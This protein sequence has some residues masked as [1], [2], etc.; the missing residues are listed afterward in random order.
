MSF[1]CSQRIKER[2]I[3]LFNKSLES[4]GFQDQ[5]VLFISIYGSH[6]YGTATETS[7]FDLLVVINS[8][9]DND[10]HVN[11]EISDH[12]SRSI[13]IDDVYDSDFMSVT[14]PQKRVGVDITITTFSSFTAA[15]LKGEP[16]AIE[17]IC[18]PE[19]FIL[20]TLRI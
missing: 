8:E 19:P 15:L 3:N 2:L 9:A 5:T 13:L 18:T 20:T 1:C 12:G 14:N 11:T 10:T 7:D 4:N 16:Y 17:A 6:V